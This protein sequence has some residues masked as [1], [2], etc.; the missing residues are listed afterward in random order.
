MVLYSLGSDLPDV[1]LKKAILPTGKFER[2]KNNKNNNKNKNKNNNNNNN[3]NNKNKNKQVQ[4][5]S[6]TEA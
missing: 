2:Q 5:A 6:M 1:N 3:N 4:D